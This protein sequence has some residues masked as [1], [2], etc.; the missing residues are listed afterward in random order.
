MDIVQDTFLRLYQKVDSY[1]E[2]KNFD[3]WIFQIAKNLCIDHY[4]K[5]YSRPNKLFKESNIE[6]MDLMVD[7]SRGSYHYAPFTHG[8]TCPPIRRACGTF[9]SL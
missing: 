2:G 5:N 3:S 1:Q 4:R 6:E 7:E 9:V 8:Q